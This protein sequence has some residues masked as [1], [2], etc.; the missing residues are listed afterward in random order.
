[1]FDPQYWYMG[2]LTL[3]IMVLEVCAAMYVAKHK[4]LARI[5]LWCMAAFMLVYEI[6]YFVE[7]PDSM[8][9]AFSTFTYF[10]FGLAVFI[11]F[12]PIKSVAAFCSIIAGG[13]YVCGFIFYPQTIY[14]RQPGEASRLIAY[15]LHHILFCGGLFLYSQYEVKK[16]DLAYVGGFLAFIVVYVELA[17]HVFHNSNAN[18]TTIGTIEATVIQ[19]LFPNFVIPWWWYIVWYLFVAAAF[20]GLWEL[21]RFINRKM[22][23]Q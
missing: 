4:W 6:K 10:L 15:L 11:P 14:A 16:I 7:H 5:V 23:R 9:L 22:L 17:I 18:N 2:L 8:P 1:M 13:L 3:L 20:W 19:L 21:T 12:R